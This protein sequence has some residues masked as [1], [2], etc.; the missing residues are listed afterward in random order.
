[1]KKVII[2]YILLFA[3]VVFNIDIISVIGIFN[4][5]KLSPKN[6]L[7]NILIPIS[8]G[9]VFL[10]FLASIIK[11]K[12]F[13]LLLVII[14]VPL[15]FI[16]SILIW[17]ALYYGS[18]IDIEVMHT[19]L[20]SNTAETK[21]FIS[22]VFNY[23]MIL[24]ILILTIP[25]ILIFFMKPYKIKNKILL[26]L[27][28]IASMVTFILIYDKRWI[29]REIAITKIAEVY[30]KTNEDRIK[31]MQILAE[32]DNKT[33]Q[34]ENITSYLSKD[35]KQVFVFVINESQNKHHFS[36]Y[37]YKNKTTPF[38]DSI[39]DE[40]FV[41]NDVVS[42]SIFTNSS[43]EKMITFSDN[44]NKLKGYEAGNIIT[45][46]K[47]AGFHT[48]WF[49]NQYF[50]GEHES[51]YSAIAYRS[52]TTHYLNKISGH[53]LETK[54]FDDAL[55]PLFKKALKDNYNKKFIVLHFMGSHAPFE[56]RY[57][58]NFGSFK[59]NLGLKDISGSISKQKSIATYD[60]SIEFTDHI[61][62]D[63]ISDLKKDNN[64]SYL[65]FLSDHGVDVYDTDPNIEFTR[66]MSNL[67]QS[68]YEIPF[69][70]WFSDEYKNSYPEIINSTKS[71]L[72]KPYQTDRVDHTIIDL[73]R[74]KHEIFKSEDSIISI[75]Y[76]TKERFIGE[77]PVDIYK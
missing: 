30:A 63:I 45:F 43:V 52:D 56:A 62:K 76:K 44:H 37:G 70:I 6:H 22:Y 68:M 38:L 9:F 66:S 18:F 23:K 34:F 20:N 54:N 73:S 59:Y 41:F 67:T 49:S 8:V 27:M 40:L 42:P 74:L 21:E 29:K 17:Y 33:V 12:Y 32:A 10:A 75:D 47:N 72:N 26:S 5:I 25:Y 48:Y 13:K 7:K 60:N 1:M 50:L 19:I 61:L 31:F 46:F 53:F 77:I 2:F 16:N 14:T 24:T 4:D 65:L 55:I 69:F 35:K 39:S 11:E 3:F 51:A 57:P 71:S 15:T 36:L 58:S 28:L 64:E